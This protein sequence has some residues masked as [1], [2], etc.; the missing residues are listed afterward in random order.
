MNSKGR[1]THINRLSGT[2]TTTTTRNRGK[3]PRGKG[4]EKERSERVVGRRVRRVRDQAP[5]RRTNVQ[6]DDQ[7]VR[8]RNGA[9][10]ERER[11]R[12]RE[13]NGPSR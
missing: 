9:A 8:Q 7:T 5:R 12:E 2:T 13:R 11:E 1:A 6:P 10:I 4:E 3:E